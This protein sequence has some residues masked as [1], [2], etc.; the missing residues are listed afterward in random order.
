MIIF[1]FYRRVALV[2]ILIRAGLDL[3]PK[4]TKKLFGTIMKLALGPWLIET[5]VIALTTNLLLGLPWGWA[6]MLG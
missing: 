2:I 1:F 6:F 3:D 5:C 4:A